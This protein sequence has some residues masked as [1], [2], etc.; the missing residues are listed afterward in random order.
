M[1][2]YMKLLNI[3]IFVDVIGMMAACMCLC[4]LCCVVL[5]SVGL[6]VACPVR[7]RS[8]QPNTTQHNLHNH[9]HAAIIPITSTNIE[10]FNNFIYR[11]VI[12]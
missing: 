12:F 11:S 1:F 3:S 10:I 2:L 6:I 5:C 9:K 4:R 7:Q 8:D